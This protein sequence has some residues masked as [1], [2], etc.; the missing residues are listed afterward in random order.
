MLQSIKAVEEQEKQKIYELQQKQ[1]GKASIAKV[2]LDTIQSSV[3][4]NDNAN[5]QSKTNAMKESY[6]SNKDK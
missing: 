4:S 5:V 6:G 3:A 1:F 2:G